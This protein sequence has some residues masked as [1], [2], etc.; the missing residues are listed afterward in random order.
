MGRP[1]LAAMLVVF[2]AGCGGSGSTSGG[3]TQPTTA[4]SP[5]THP[6]TQ[7]A[8]VPAIPTGLPK[9]DFKAT[10]TGSGHQALV[11]HPWTFTVRARALNGKPISGTVIAQVLLGGKV[12]DTIGWFA[13]PGTFTKTFAFTGAERG[14]TITFRTKIVAN[15]G[16]KPV[17][18]A[19]TV[20]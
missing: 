3:G 10:L 18:Y 1:V 13:F 12:I 8:P 16:T 19:V 20:G 11:G 14:K 2:A 9:P 6:K 15:G 5:P 4:A 7:P 17:D